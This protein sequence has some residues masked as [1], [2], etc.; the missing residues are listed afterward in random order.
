MAVT[1]VLLFEDETT[2]RL[3][4]S[5]RRVWSFTGEQGHI[6]ITGR[7]DQRVLFGTIN[8]STGHRVVMVQRFMRQDGF[9]ALLRELRRVYKGRPIWMILDNATPHKT[10]KSLALAYQLN[11]S[12]IWLP[13]QCSELNAMDHLWRSVKEKVSSNYQYR[14]VN[15]HATTAIEYIHNLSN[16]AALRKAGILSEKFWLKS[17]L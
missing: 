7:N 10:S 15:E 3:F 4:P 8:I 2:I 17:F 14:D 6:G 1:A 13:K 5:I 11:I 16:K 9:Q 12:L